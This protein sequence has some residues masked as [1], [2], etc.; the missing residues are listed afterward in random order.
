MTT[1]G[2]ILGQ[3]NDR[4][5]VYGLLL[6]SGNAALVARLDEKAD[7][8]ADDPCGVALKAVQAFTNQADE[9]AWVKLMGSIR[10][11]QSPAGACLGEMIT[12]SMTR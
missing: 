7:A 12:W 10:G 9:E 6:E 3:L 2:E 11:S 1:L 8:T 4:D 5:Q